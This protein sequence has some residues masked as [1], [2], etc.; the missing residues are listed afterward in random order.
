LT[1]N[2]T[3][4]IIEE[5]LKGDV[6]SFELIIG[7]YE[8]LVFNIIN[9]KIPISL[10][11]LNEDIAQEVFIKVFYNLPSYKSEYSFINWIYTITHN[12]I[13]DFLKKEKL[14]KKENITNLESVV[15]TNEAFFE[16]DVFEV[17]I[18]RN[19]INTLSVKYQKVL[20][21]YYNEGKGTSEIAEILNVNE[22]TIKTWLLRARKVLKKKLKKLKPK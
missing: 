15:F 3:L 19:A 4:K 18:I 13:K 17:E 9:S 10:K 6:K 16:N 5:I 20:F 12:V 8:K 7:Q 22:N 1:N 11:Y 14:N 21:F 2:N